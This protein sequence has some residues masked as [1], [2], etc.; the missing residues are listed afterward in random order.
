MGSAHEVRPLEFVRKRVEKDSEKAP[1]AKLL[2]QC[3][4]VGENFVFG[5]VDKSVH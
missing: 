3:S 4:E 2:S 1:W 5:Q